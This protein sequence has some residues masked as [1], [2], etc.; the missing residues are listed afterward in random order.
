[1]PRPS[2][3]GKIVLLALA[4]WASGQLALL[5]AIPPGFTT[6]IFPPLGIGLACALL[7]GRPMAIGV[8]LGSTLLNLSITWS[9]TGT[10]TLPGLAIALSIACASSAQCL[11]AHW[12]I[13]RWVGFPNPLTDERSI[14]RLLLLGGPLTCL[15]SAAGGNLVLLQAGLL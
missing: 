10:L 12:F 9:Q 15:L 7:W 1:M 14:F 2:L 13:H 3:T 6:A 11:L 4:Y 5:L 8:L